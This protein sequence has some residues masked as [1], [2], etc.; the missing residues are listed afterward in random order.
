[1]N[2]IGVDVQEPRADYKPIKAVLDD[3]IYLI[4][5]GQ[6]LK[7]EYVHADWEQ[8][9]DMTTATPNIQI[10]SIEELM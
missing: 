4:T 10:D 3:D 2:F 8:L 9:C 7:L 5:T 1:M 6:V